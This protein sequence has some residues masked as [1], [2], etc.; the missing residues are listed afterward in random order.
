MVLCPLEVTSAASKLSQCVMLPPFQFPFEHQ[1]G[2]FT[3]PD[4]NQRP[5]VATA[6]ITPHLMQPESGEEFIMEMFGCFLVYQKV[7]FSFQHVFFFFLLKRRLLLEAG[8]CLLVIYFIETK[9]NQFFL[10]GMSC[11][12]LSSLTLFVLLLFSWF[13]MPPPLGIITTR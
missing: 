6:F 5:V 2:F 10:T 13:Y 4:Q 8:P 12:R 11:S 7:S 1:N 3:L 9:K